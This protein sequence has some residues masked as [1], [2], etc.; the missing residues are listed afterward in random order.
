MI[1][2]ENI[3]DYMRQ[4]TYRPLSYQELIAVLHIEDQD[5][6]QFAKAMGRLQKDGEV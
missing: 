1:S 2:N 3:L 4:E 6:E 5:Q